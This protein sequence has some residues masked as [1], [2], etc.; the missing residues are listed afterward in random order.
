MM[1][2]RLLSMLTLSVSGRRSHR[3]Q[4][5]GEHIVNMVGSSNLIYAIR[6]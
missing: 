1:K 6:R 4:A 2:I 3:P 5:H